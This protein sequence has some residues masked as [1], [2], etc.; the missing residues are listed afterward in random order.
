MVSLPYNP[1]LIEK[2][3]ATLPGEPSGFQKIVSQEIKRM[4]EKTFNVP[5]HPFSMDALLG[6][7]IVENGRLGQVV[8]DR[9]IGKIRR[10]RRAPK[11]EALHILA[12]IAKIGEMEENPLALEASARLEIPGLTPRTE[13]NNWKSGARTIPYDGPP[14]RRGWNRLTTDE[15]DRRIKKFLESRRL[16]KKLEMAAG[17]VDGEKKE[18]I[19]IT[20]E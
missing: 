12:A 14:I 3:K 18:I 10:M 8:A 7:Q 2:M 19:C 1:F 13:S 4:E 16:M 6:S 9:K 20:L 5:I 11:S 17:E 15:K